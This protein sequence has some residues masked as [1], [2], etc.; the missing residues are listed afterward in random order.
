M[1]DYNKLGQC[2]DN[3]YASDVSACS[4][5]KVITK[6]EGNIL[7][8]NFRTIANIDKHTHLDNQMKRLEDEAIQHIKQK[9]KHIHDCYRE[10]CSSSLK[11][12]G[13]RNIRRPSAHNMARLLLTEET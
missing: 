7:K 9:K 11:M 5:R 13:S 2:I 6:L 1:V 12:K 8:L 3:V 4:S 10:L